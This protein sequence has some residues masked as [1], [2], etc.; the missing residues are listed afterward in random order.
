MNT[1]EE[2][3]EL[4]G[5]L[6]KARAQMT[7]PKKGEVANA[8]TYRYTYADLAS[9]WEAVRAPL[10]SNGLSVAQFPEVDGNSVSVETRLFHESGQWLSNSL[11]LHAAKPDPQGIGSAITYARRYSLMA[12]VGIAPEDDDGKAAMPAHADAIN[13]ALNQPPRQPRRSSAPAPKKAPAPPVTAQAAVD[14][15]PQQGVSAPAPPKKK[16]GLLPGEC[17]AVLSDKCPGYTQLWEVDE[18]IEKLEGLKT[19]SKDERHQ[20]MVL[21]KQRYTEITNESDSTTGGDTDHT[22]RN[23]EEEA[24]VNSGAGG[25][26]DAS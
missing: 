21:L 2:I 22:G 5:A 15:L 18:A 8:G 14:S 10:T 11:T 17:L 4:V 24:E 23:G 19:L 1:S 26:D 7:S 16:R 12:L 13:Q 3:S 20:C 9:V 6:A 25:S